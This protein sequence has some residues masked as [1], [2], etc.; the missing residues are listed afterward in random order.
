MLVA[1]RFA[2]HDAREFINRVKRAAQMLHPQQQRLC[3]ELVMNLNQNMENLRSFWQTEAGRMVSKVIVNMH[4][5]PSNGISDFIPLLE[6][7]NI[8]TLSL[9]SYS[10]GTNS[11]ISAI[12]EHAC[13]SLR[14]IEVS[15]LKLCDFDCERFTKAV[16]KSKVQRLE[17][18]APISLRKRVLDSLTSNSLLSLSIMLDPTLIDP[19]VQCISQQITQCE[20]EFENFSDRDDIYLF[21]LLPPTICT[22]TLRGIGLSQC[23]EEEFLRFLG[24][25][26]ITEL[27][28][29]NCLNV[30]ELAIGICPSSSK[31]KRLDLTRGCLLTSAGLGRLFRSLRA[32]GNGLEEL[33]VSVDCAVANLTSC[34]KDL[35]ITM[36]HPNNKLKQL[37]VLNCNEQGEGFGD[38]SF[39]IICEAFRHPN[40]MLA[41]ERF[42]C[43][44]PISP[45]IHPRLLLRR[46]NFDRSMYAMLSVH[47]IQRLSGK[48]CTV[49]RLPREL[50]RMVANHLLKW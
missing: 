43:D 21:Q 4:C 27:T 35:A 1:Q 23:A 31:L 14:E 6:A 13:V 26:E 16:N 11:Y 48:K 20:L 2:S 17:F 28:L 12:L 8:D 7:P 18:I 36:R 38:Q 22:L 30:N 10:N 37:R 3:V 50:I 40:C 41:P 32:K 24:K 46:V 9:I 15:L 42:V 25:S 44:N 49:H 39:T 47:L 19:F 29:V 45:R 34:C 33:S 5:E